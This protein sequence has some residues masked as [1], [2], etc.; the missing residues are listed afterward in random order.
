MS[1][2]PASGARFISF[3]GAY[4][5]AGCKKG[6]N[7][8]NPD[9]H[10]TGCASAHRSTL[11]AT[12]V[13]W[14]D[15]FTNQICPIVSAEEVTFLY[16]RTSIGLVYA[17]IGLSNPRKAE[18]RSLEVKASWTPVQPCSA[19][20]STWSFNSDWNKTAHVMSLPLMAVRIRFPM[21]GR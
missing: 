21:S 17:T 15:S 9:I 11:P 1:T 19:C 13:S 3:M 8:R 10:F 18:L 20:L 7:I 6:K 2:A 5:N 16:L 4:Y 14:S 12:L